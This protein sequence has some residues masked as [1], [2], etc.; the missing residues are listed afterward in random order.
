MSHILL[1]TYLLNN[2]ILQD[3]YHKAKKSKTLAETLQDVRHKFLF[4]QNK[5]TDLKY[6]YFNRCN[7][8]FEGEI[9]Q[10]FSLFVFDTE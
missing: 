6:R 8:C 4:L 3:D 2:S 5:C 7:Y 9:I 10:S 1:F